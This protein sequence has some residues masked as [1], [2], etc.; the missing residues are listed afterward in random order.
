MSLPISGDPVVFNVVFSSTGG[1]PPLTIIPLTLLYPGTSTVRTLLPQEQVTIV[2][3][4]SF[5]NGPI[6]IINNSTA[7]STITSNNLMLA[8]NDNAGESVS[9]HDDGT[10]A[11][12]GL[13]GIVPQIESVE[14]A[15]MT[16]YV[17]GTGVINQNQG[18]TSRPPWAAKLTN[19][20]T[21]NF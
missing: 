6:F 15:G 20:S 11:L 2:S 13:P 7:G 17:S 1:A 14:G 12:T 16:L 18:Y 3:V 10:Y 21:G 19:N 9:W 8:L 5:C 4:E